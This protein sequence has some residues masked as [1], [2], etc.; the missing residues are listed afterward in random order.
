YPPQA[1][2]HRRIGRARA[3]LPGEAGGIARDPDGARILNGMGLDGH[4]LETVERSRVRDLVLVEELAKDLDALLQ[5]AHALARADRHRGVLERLRRAR[6]VGSAETHGQPRAP[7]GQHV[8]ARP[9]VR[10]EHGMPMDER[11]HAPDAEARARR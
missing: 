1:A 7:T 2:L 9:L 3:S 10:E 6:L 5:P 8:E 11:R 4:A